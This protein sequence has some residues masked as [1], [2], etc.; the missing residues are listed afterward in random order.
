M[1]R[2]VS[3]RDHVVLKTRSLEPICEVSVH[4]EELATSRFPMSNMNRREFIT[5][6]GGAAA[7]WPLAARAQQ[8]QMPV[9][10]FLRT[11]SF[12]DQLEYLILNH[13]PL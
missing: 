2:V 12:V 5:V 4:D 13:L 1:L 7:V 3:L 8:A 6:L 11:T 9:I 10:G